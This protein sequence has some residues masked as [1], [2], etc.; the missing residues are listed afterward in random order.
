MRKCSCNVSVKLQVLAHTLKTNWPIVDLQN[1]TRR[2]V[3]ILASLTN[4]LTNSF[5]L[6]KGQVHGE[7]RDLF[8]QKPKY[9]STIRHRNPMLYR[10]EKHCS[11]L[12]IPITIGASKWQ[13]DSHLFFCIF[14]PSF[15]SAFIRLLIT[16]PSGIGK[17]KSTDHLSAISGGCHRTLQPLG[18]N[19]CAKSSSLSAKLPLFG[20]EPPRS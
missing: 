3:S 11:N 18:H 10:E 13:E 2:K 12:Q 1:E 15:S 9:Q 5:F 16:R 4:L 8:K 20:S 7:V 19:H 6:R 14:P 17:E